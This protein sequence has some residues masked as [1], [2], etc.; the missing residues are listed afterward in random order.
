MKRV[1]FDM[2]R[3]TQF[4]PL[5]SCTIIYVSSNQNPKGKGRDYRVSAINIEEE[6]VLHNISILGLKLLLVFANSF[7]KNRV[8]M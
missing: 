4:H 8:N 7:D 5:V 6:Y 2:G 3:V 1:Y